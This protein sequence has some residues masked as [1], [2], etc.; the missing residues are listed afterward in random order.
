[1]LA[2]DWRV[3]T[4]RM[5]GSVS[6]CRCTMDAIWITGSFSASGKI[7]GK[8]QLT[9]GSNFAFAFHQICSGLTDQRHVTS[10]SLCA[11]SY[12]CHR[13]RNLHTFS[14]CTLN[15]KAKDSERCDPLPVSL[16]R[17]TYQI[18]PSHIHFVLTQG[19]LKD[20]NR[21]KLMNIVHRAWWNKL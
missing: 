21:K 3:K 15:V 18:C 16:C 4:V 5:K 7:P 19:Y 2:Q 13:E 20:K 10:Y 14:S 11:V 17:V 6:P 1:M 8:R 9:A 12:V